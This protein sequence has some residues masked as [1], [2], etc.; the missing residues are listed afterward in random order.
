MSITNIPVFYEGQDDL[1]GML[2]TSIC[3][4]CYNTE[5]FIN[6]YILDCG[7][8]SFNKK[9]LENLKKKF[10]NFSI[11]YIPID[12]KQ[13]EGLE[14]YTQGNY[15]DCYSRSLI[16]EL[17]PELDKA[18]YLDTD[19][20]ALDDIKKLWNEDLNGYE[21]GAAA[22]IGYGKGF[23]RNATENLGVSKQHIMPN[24]GVALIDC[25]KWR[26]NNVSEKMLE[27]ARKYKGKLLIMQESLISIYYN[28]N[29][30][31]L[32]NNRYN[33]SDRLNEVKKY[34]PHITDEYLEN[35]KQNVILQHLTPFKPWIYCKNSHNNRFLLHFE[36]FWFFAKMTPFYEGL[37]NKFNYHTIMLNR[38]YE[39]KR[40]N[41]IIKLFGFIT[42]LKIKNKGNKAVYKLFNII[43]IFKIKS[44]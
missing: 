21:I 31:K 38:S 4:V 39:I 3:S 12:L 42:F 22:D 37:L 36:N 20:I 27:I 11:E 8:H 7:I 34:F 9:Q 13:F 44:I 29:N 2:A 25:K 26:E 24:I 15:V 10:N 5:S 41:K 23:F 1:I 43:P 16:P 32:L 33:M 14:G 28:N 35:E 19:V 40:T 18:I 6:F 30:Y 17:V